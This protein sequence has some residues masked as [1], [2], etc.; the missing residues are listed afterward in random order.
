[1]L[2]LETTPLPLD[3][4]AFRRDVRSFLARELTE[5][6]KEPA[7]ASATMFTSFTERDI[8]LKWQAKLLAR[9]WLA[10]KLPVEFGGPGW[11]P[12][13]H[14]IFETEAGL[15]GAPFLPGFG[16]VYVA[17]VLVAF[18]TERQKAELIPRILEGQDYYCQGFSEPG[19]G[20]DLASLQCAA[21]RSGSD[22]VIDGSKIW[23]TQ[24]HLADHIFCLVRTS[25]EE[26]PQQ[27][28][29]FLL[30]D[31]RLP[32]ITIKPIRLIG[33]DLDLNQ[34]FFEGVRVPSTNLVGNEGEG[35]K[36][37][38]H[39]LELER[40]GFVMSGYL[41]HRLRRLRRLFASESE[42]AGGLV[43]SRHIE[44]RLA[45]LDLAVLNFSHFELKSILGRQR[46]VLEKAQPSIIKI[47]STDLQHRIDEL[48]MD[49]LG[50]AGRYFCA[51]RPLQPVGPRIAGRAYLQPFAPTMLNNR[52]LSIEGGSHEIQRNLIARA[53][54][55]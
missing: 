1:M 37:A 41:E 30:V 10:P 7:L 6:L 25:R 2:A 27:G 16:L 54:T 32:G 15:A 24:A 44:S 53:V 14:F 51:E 5:D 9:R 42:R 45:E 13:Q 34:V 55:R 17:P 50:S 52:A 36:V 33:G 43:E 19:S 12:L 47:L 31:M 29:S 28:I 20:S 22:Y 49:V 38:K 48:A 39:L 23:T 26:R 46:G 11:T 35:W 3:E 8:A 21:R 40:G 4:E 18:G